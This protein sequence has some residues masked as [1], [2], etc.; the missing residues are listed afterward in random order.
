[1]MIQTTVLETPI[2][3]L[4]L[5]ALDAD[6]QAAFRGQASSQGQAT[7]IGQATSGPTLIASGF[8]GDPEELRARL[9]PSLRAYGLEP[10]TDLGAIGTAHEAYFGGDL[11]AL[12]D[13]PCTSRGHGA[14]R[15]CGRPCGRCPPGRP[16][17]TGNSP[18]RPVWKGPPG[19]PARPA[20]RT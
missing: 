4:A 17:P 19:P 3:P 15:R 7:G 13:P 16:S 10:V 11:G 8:T 6:G 9:H 2:G 5:L 12:D 20:R 1:M 14:G 18:P